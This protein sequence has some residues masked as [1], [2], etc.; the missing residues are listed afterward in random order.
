MEAV[1]VLVAGA[2][3]AGL[4][5]AARLVRGGKRVAV[6]DRVA[7][8]DHKIGEC[9][10]ASVSRLLAKLGLPPLEHQGH[11]RVRGAV[12]LWAGA[13]HHHDFLREPDG[14]AWR[15]DRVAFERDIERCAIEAGALRCEGWV[16]TM[17]RRESDWVVTTDDGAQVEARF[18]IDASGRRAFIGRA[19]RVGTAKGPPLVALWAIGA[20]AM[21][22]PTDRTF[23]ETS[24]DGWWYGAWLPD[25]RPVAVFH[26]GP[27]TARRMT[28]EPES[29]RE[30]LAKTRLLSKH[31]SPGSFAASMPAVAE[32]RSR[33]QERV[34]GVGWGACG[35]AAISFDPIASQGI[36][37]AL[38]TG[39]ML[40]TS[41]LGD[42]R[43]PGCFADYATRIDDIAAIY[44]GR[45]EAF[46]R[47]AQ[48]HHC[49][50]FWA[51][52][53]RAQPDRA[54]A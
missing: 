10:P 42:G 40:A 16:Q 29:W 50:R 38:A 45:R 11:R 27:E 31:I 19:M 14:A 21:S 49:T 44:A 51:E 35:D 18:L 34:V 54:G 22:M 6:V 46:Y 13:L 24:D 41:V 30:A 20:P 25:R 52:Q 48:R 39:E 47:A 32:A 23:T 36:F 12:S 2:G 4:A 1:D 15:V 17:E 33:W 8:D 5:A 9:V 3:P 43:R 53:L 37:N 7:G 28:R 26:T